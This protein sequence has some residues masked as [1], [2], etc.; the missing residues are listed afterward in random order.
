MQGREPVYG[1]VFL[2]RYK[3]DDAGQQEEGC[4]DYVWFANQVRTVPTHGETC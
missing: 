3:E 2:F 4:P 1:L